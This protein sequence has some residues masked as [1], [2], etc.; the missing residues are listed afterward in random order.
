MPE[1][2]PYFFPK[3]PDYDSWPDGRLFER[4]AQ[5]LDEIDE[6]FSSGDGITDKDYHYLMQKS[7]NFYQLLDFTG[8]LRIELETELFAKDLEIE[9]LKQQLKDALGN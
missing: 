4:K 9:N 1:N 5:L 6:R 3:Q 8:N 2:A 7:T